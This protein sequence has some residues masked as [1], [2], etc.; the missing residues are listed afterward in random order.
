M[1]I[2]SDKLLELKYRLDKSQ[3]TF[4]VFDKLINLFLHERVNLSKGYKPSY[5]NKKIVC[6]DIFISSVLPFCSPYFSDEHSRVDLV[7]AQNILAG[8]YRGCGFPANSQQVCDELDVAATKI[9]IKTAQ[10]TEIVPFAVYVANEGK[11]RV[12]L[13][14]K[15]NRP[16]RA[17][18]Y[19]TNYPEPD[20]LELIRFIPFGCMGLR[21]VG[22]SPQSIGKV[23]AWKII[24]T[25]RLG[26]VVVLGFR[27]SVDILETYG[28]KFGGQAF[29]P[30]AMF[31]AAKIRIFVSGNFYV[32]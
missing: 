20:E 24:Q 4:S 5:V 31:L 11:N 7:P 3:Y 16:I 9:S 26:S 15:I 17:L 19:K 13:Y 12:D 21:Y 14:R 22:S 18:V 8:N 28:V 10:Y 2:I 6:G 27:E 32:N 29:A 1:K 30:Y 23:S 25:T